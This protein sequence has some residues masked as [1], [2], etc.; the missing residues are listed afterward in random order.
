VARHKKPAHQGAPHVEKDESEVRWLISYSDFMMQL[1]C[2]FILLYSVANI[3]A[4][5]AAQVAAYYRASIGLGDPPVHE[6]PAPGEK[7][8]VGERPLVGGEVAGA[9]VPADVRHSVQEV[10]GG[11][12]VTFSEPLFESG[13]AD[14]PPRVA[15]ALERITAPL[16][17]FVGDVHVTGTAGPDPADALGGDALRLAQARAQAVAERLAREGLSAA[18]DPRFTVPAGRTTEDAEDSRRARILLKTR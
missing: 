12:L 4:G 14:L 5:K 7:V 15:E 16:R 3:D 1:V 9:D 11:W 6:K 10:P 17:P 13:S 2:L 8:S 18:F